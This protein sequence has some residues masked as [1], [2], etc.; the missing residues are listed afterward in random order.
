MP[1]ILLILNFNIP[2]NKRRP[3]KYYLLSDKNIIFI[4]YRMV[5]RIEKKGYIL[6]LFII[7]KIIVDNLSKIKYI[8]IILTLVHKQSK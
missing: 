5:I 1:S 4:L 2:F 3:I 8:D 6:V 7:L